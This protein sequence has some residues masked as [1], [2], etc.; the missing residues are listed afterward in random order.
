[1]KRLVYVGLSVALTVSASVSPL[2]ACGNNAPEVR[3][4][5]SAGCHKYCD[6]CACMYGWDGMNCWSGGRIICGTYTDHLG[7]VRECYSNECEADACQ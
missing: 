4:V 2:W 1:M 6:N 3:Q 5:W 7:N